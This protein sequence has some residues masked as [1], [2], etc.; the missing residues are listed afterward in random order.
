MSSTR[1]IQRAARQPIATCCTQYTL[2]DVHLA[3]PVRLLQL[4]HPAACRGRVTRSHRITACAIRC[5]I[6]PTLSSRKALLLWVTDQG[7]ARCTLK[8]NLADASEEPMEVLRL[9]KGQY[10][11]ERALLND[12]PRAAN[13]IAINEVLSSLHSVACA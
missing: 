13:V 10:F 11:G 3:Q 7:E 5:V 4:P 2:C 1:C 9:Q 6:A 8:K 12:A